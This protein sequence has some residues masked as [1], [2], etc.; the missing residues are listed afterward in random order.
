MS[1]VELPPE[2][3]LVKEL[4]GGTGRGIYLCHCGKIF[5]TTKYRIQDG[6]TKSCG[7]YR[8]EFKNRLKHGRT[9][10]PMYSSWMAM[11]KRCLKPIHKQYK[12]YGGRGITICKRWLK[13]ENFLADMGECPKGYSIDRI[14]N[15]GNYEP[16]NCRWITRSEN[17][18]KGILERKVKLANHYIEGY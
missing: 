17:A 14:D 5:V 9:N 11:K 2:P 8:K 18:R 15:D 6:T 10:S 7:C 4:Y 1:F 3:Q 12:D 16:S 13:F